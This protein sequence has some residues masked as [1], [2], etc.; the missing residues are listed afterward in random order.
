MPGVEEKSKPSSE[1]KDENADLSKVDVQQDAVVGKEE[2][3]LKTDGVKD[4]KMDEAKEPSNGATK[5]EEEAPAHGLPHETVPQP[6]L[7]A[8]K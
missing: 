6:N 2:E 8:V 7:D 4:V 1:D 5:E 3:P